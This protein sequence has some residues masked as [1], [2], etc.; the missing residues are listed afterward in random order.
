MNFEFND[1]TKKRQAVCISAIL[2]VLCGVLCSLFGE[3]FLA[4]TAALL[5]ALFLF[6]NGNKRI[7]SF[8][9][10][11]LIII[12]NVFIGGLYSVLGIAPLVLAIIIY[13]M[14]AKGRD[15]G[16]CVVALTAT[17][18]LLILISLYFAAVN[19]TESFDFEA[20]T[21]FY[22]EMYEGLKTDFIRQM[23]ELS[24][25]NPSLQEPI[26]SDEELTLLFDSMARQLISMLVII[27]FVISGIALKLFCALIYRFEKEPHVVVGWRFR[28]TNVFA[29]FYAV[30]LFLNLFIGAGYGV[31]E[32]IIINL[33]NIFMVV[34]AYFGFTV[35]SAF[36]ARGRGRG[37]A[38]AILV[39]GIVLLS[40]LAL[41][42]LS[43]IGLIF[44]VMDNKRNA[45]KREN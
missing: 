18:S 37:F 38:T 28:V 36:L 43:V 45:V 7:F 19:M 11:A 5:A 12:I 29:Y 3:V 26:F 2:A 4:P 34:F 17:A 33:Y 13:F 44:T 1:I 14:Y 40:A 15:K 35:A 8:I 16:E 21:G 20:V 42:I 24:S 23:S 6:E 41:Q 9:M 39:F 31:T 10:P 27:S 30:L 25:I 22:L 32:L